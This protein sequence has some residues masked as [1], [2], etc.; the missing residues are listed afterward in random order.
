MKYTIKFKNR[1]GN[2]ETEINAKRLK[3]VPYDIF[4][5]MVFLCTLD[6]L[7]K[8]EA[9]DNDLI[10]GLTKL[11]CEADADERHNLIS[12]MFCE[13]RESGFLDEFFCNKE[14]GDGHGN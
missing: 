10:V 6:E 13:I 8:S 3:S 12:Q 5:E 7:I 1:D 11:L 14:G 9:I 4:I 2:I